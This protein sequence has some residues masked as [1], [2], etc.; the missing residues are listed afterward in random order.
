MAT[1]RGKC[2][3]TNDHGAVRC[4]NGAS[5]RANGVVACC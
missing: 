4:R 3:L 1:G 2:A 5:M